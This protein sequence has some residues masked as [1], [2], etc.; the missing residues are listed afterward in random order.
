MPVLCFNGETES[1]LTG[2]AVNGPPES[3]RQDVDLEERRQRQTK[4]PGRRTG[5]GRD[6]QARHVEL[7]KH[8]VVLPALRATPGA[9]AAAA[10]RVVREVR[11]PANSEPASVLRQELDASERVA[12]GP[13][14]RRD[15]GGGGLLLASAGARYGH[16]SA[17]F[18]RGRQGLR[19]GKGGGGAWFPRICEFLKGC[20]V[21]RGGSDA[22]GSGCHWVIG[23]GHALLQRCCGAAVRWLQ[24]GD[25]ASEPP[26]AM[27][28]DYHGLIALIFVATCL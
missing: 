12:A 28:T 7:H 20:E 8:R 26:V 4:E 11:V 22:A 19:D 25:S 23:S 5:H 21:R 14:L 16:T 17:A 18:R 10:L 1:Y 6:V 15:S 2:G 9:H 27:A 24:A 13:R 3:L